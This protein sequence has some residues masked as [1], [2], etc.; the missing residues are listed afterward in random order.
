MLDSYN[1][2]SRIPSGMDHLLHRVC[3]AINK[4]PQSHFV[5]ISDANDFFIK[6]RLFWMKPAVVPTEILSN[7][8][9]TSPDKDYLKIYPFDDQYE[10]STCSRNMCKGKA[11]KNY[12]RRNGPFTKIY[13]TGDGSNDAC[14]AQLLSENDVLFVRQGL[15]LAKIIEKGF[16]KGL[17]IRIDAKIV[18]FD[19][20][21]TIE[22]AMM[23]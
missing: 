9:A 22:E 2:L 16:Y 7:H 21:L 14:P 10:C 17:R 1:K 20:A 19:N 4:R 13:Y 3:Q 5:I 15:S 12:V 6:T 8:A 11:L 18:Y 23:F